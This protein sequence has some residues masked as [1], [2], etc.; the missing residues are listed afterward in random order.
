MCGPRCDVGVAIY[1]RDRRRDADV[2]AD[3]DVDAI[4]T[5]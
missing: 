2:D 4:T 3:V 5:R 1:E